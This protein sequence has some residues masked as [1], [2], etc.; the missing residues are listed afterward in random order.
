M[1]DASRRGKL[2]KALSN[3]WSGPARTGELA[4]EAVQEELPASAT[5]KDQ[6]LHLLLAA[7]GQLEREPP[8]QKDAQKDAKEAL[9]IFRDLQEAECEATA[10]LA[11]SRSSIELDVHAA[12]QAAVQALK[13]FRDLGH[14]KGEIAALHCLAKVDQATKSFDDASYKASEALKRARKIEDL[15]REMALCE[16]VLEVN[17]AQDNPKKAEDAA[18]EGGV[19]SKLLESQTLLAKAKCWTARAH[20]ASEERKMTGIKAAEEALELYRSLGQKDGEVEALEAL[21][22]ATKEDFSDVLSKSQSLAD[23]FAE[24]GDKKEEVRALLIAASCREA[25]DREKAFKL[26]QRGLNAAKEAERP[27]QGQVL[28]RIARLHMDREEPSEALRAATQAGSIFRNEPYPTKKIRISEIEC[29]EIQMD[30]HVMLGAMDEAFRVGVE[31]GRRF[32]GL[33]ERQGEGMVLLKL[34]S[35]HQ[36]RLEDDKALKLLEY[37]PML[38]SSAGDRQLEGLAWERMANCYLE[39]GDSAQ[40]VKAMQHCVGC[41]RKVNSRLMRARAAL[42]QADVQTALVSIQQGSSL[43]ALVAAKEATKLLQTGTQEP[44]LALAVQLL[45]NAHLMNRQGEEAL[46]R[47][48]ESQDLAQKQKQIGAEAMSKL[49]EAGAHLCLEDFGESARCAKEAKELFSSDLDGNGETSANDFLTYILKAE[50]KEEDPSLFRG[51]ALRRLSG[52]EMRQ[53]DEAKKKETQQQKRKSKVSHQSDIILWQCDGRSK[54]NE[55]GRSIMTYFEGFE[56]RAGVGRQQQQP[57]KT[58][59]QVRQGEAP[60][61][62][63]KDFKETVKEQGYPDREPAVFAVRWVQA[64]NAKEPVKSRRELRRKEDTRVVSVASLDAPSERCGRYAKS[65]RLEAPGERHGYRIF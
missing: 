15:S 43:E 24:S 35:L 38:F 44:W 51:F 2:D 23:K 33:Q 32:K 22:A 56:V 34:V 63:S 50:A 37:V 62:Y 7:L 64:E 12:S 16:T 29:I 61:E 65:D 4:G 28:L 46:E 25:T 13:V 45:T 53:K 60:A 18:K 6:A 54:Q 52:R 47:A 10:L 39:A 5:P 21:A 3:I 36:M 30:A 41:F 49:M 1:D 27:L 26:L 19:I 20:G 57:L 9:A 40:A 31:Q 55:D 58:A 59:E 17:I 14:V 8:Q 42:L 48:R 11:V